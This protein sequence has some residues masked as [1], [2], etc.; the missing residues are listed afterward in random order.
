MPPSNFL[1]YCGWEFSI[2]SFHF[3]NPAEEIELRGCDEIRY[4]Y[5]ICPTVVIGILFINSFYQSIG[6]HFQITVFKFGKC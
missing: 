6:F 1:A 5:H 3:E 2:K 4:A